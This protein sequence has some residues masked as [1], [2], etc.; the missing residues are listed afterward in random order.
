MS[1]Y[2]IV[3]YNEIIG[4]VSSESRATL[5]RGNG[6]CSNC[7]PSNTSNDAT[8]EVRWAEKIRGETPETDAFSNLN[9]YLSGRKVGLR[10]EHQTGL[11]APSTVAVDTAYNNRVGSDIPG[12]T[13]VASA[14]FLATDGHY[15]RRLCLLLLVG[16]VVSL[17]ALLYFGSERLHVPM[18]CSAPMRHTSTRSTKP[19]RRKRR[20]GISREIR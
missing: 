14:R 11:V 18:F 7:Y 16:R 19:Q 6:C 17:L 15:C 13:L 9:Y 5:K 12:R 10:Y 3:R 20:T 2:T 8:L 1:W 4:V